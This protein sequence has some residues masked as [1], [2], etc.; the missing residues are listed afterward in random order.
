M[1]KQ[2]KVS[3]KGEINGL[4]TIITKQNDII[5]IQ[6]NG[7]IDGTYIELKDNSDILYIE[8]LIRKMSIYLDAITD[9]SPDNDTTMNFNFKSEDLQKNY[10]LSFFI[11]FT[12]IKTI[13]EF[14]KIFQEKIVPIINDLLLS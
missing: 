4:N 14:I 13:A 7:K 6:L 2:T 9:L 10:S 11:E 5:K 1:D 12:D 8:Y 3:I